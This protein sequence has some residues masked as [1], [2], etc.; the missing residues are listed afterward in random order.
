VTR[1]LSSVASAALVLVLASAA[2]SRAQVGDA[3]VWDDPTLSEGVRAANLV[4]L[5]E[6]I[7]VGRGG[8]AAYKVVRT[9]KGAPR[10]G[11]EVLV[12]GMEK[13]EEHP[14]QA[15]V[16]VGDAAYL[17]LVGDPEGHIFSQPTPTWG[18]FPI[19]D[20]GEAKNVVV[21][22]S[23]TFVRVAIPVA[24]WERL[25]LAVIQG[26]PPAGLVGEARTALAKPAA[27]GD[28]S[29]EV[30]TDVYVALEML[31]LFGAPDDVP[32][33]VRIAKDPRF[34][35]PRQFQVRVAAAR[36]LGKI[37]GPAAVGPLL[38]LMEHDSVDVVQSLAAGAL[39][40]V[41]APIA[42]SGGAEADVRS[43]CERLAKFALDA[44]SMRITFAAATDPRKNEVESPLSAALASLAN[45]R[46]RA[47]VAPALRAL[48]R[49]EQVGAVVAGLAFFAT[50]DDPAHA[51]A[52][53]TRMRQAGAED[54]AFNRLFARTLKQITKQ[55]LGEDREAWLTWCRAQ[56]MPGAEAPLGPPAPQHDGLPP[57]GPGH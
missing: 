57:G 11:K 31:T 40:P 54:V 30:I 32:A 9:F 10:D 17:V 12:T 16:A 55:D 39:G 19:V 41:L 44:S 3:D 45:L 42:K 20:F 26:S 25:L 34:Q 38:D 51:L 18:R 27:A 7:S 21:A 33:I 23:N 6:C 56:G 36:A 43:A 46:S 53:A 2:P 35:G 5:G 14:D 48:E 15:G 13:D 49:T 22:L 47:G 1:S 52:I 37:G 29:L 50:L 24:Q 28:A 8:G 4:I